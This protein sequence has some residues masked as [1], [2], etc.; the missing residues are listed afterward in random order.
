MHGN[1]LGGPKRRK[2]NL[3]YGRTA[4]VRACM[5]SK[6]RAVVFA[7]LVLKSRV[8]VQSGKDY[9]SSHLGR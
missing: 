6:I 7:D 1:V 4:A 9:T 8:C 3:F 2:G 5:A